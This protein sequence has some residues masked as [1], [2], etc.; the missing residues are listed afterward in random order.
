MGSQQGVICRVMQLDHEADPGLGMS[1]AASGFIQHEATGG[2]YLNLKSDPA[3][4]TKF[5][6]GDALPVLHDED[7]EGGRAS[8]TYCPAFQA[9]KKRIAEGRSRLLVEPEPETVAAGVTVDP[10]EDPVQM[11]RDLEEFGQAA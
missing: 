2:V 3:T 6:H 11:R 9:E 4:V 7:V 1:A 8:Y 10:L 5:C